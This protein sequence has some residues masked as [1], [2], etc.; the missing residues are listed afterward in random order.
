[1][2]PPLLNPLF[3]SAQSLPGVGPRI[4]ALIARAVGADGDDALVRDLLFHLPN[5][6]VD[7]RNRPPLYEMP[8]SGYV[9]VEGVVERHRAAAAGLG[10]ALAH[11]PGGGQ[12]RD[13]GRLFQSAQ[14]TG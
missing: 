12:R 13:P 14:P 8:P 5:G 10:G 2:R 1:M 4:E 9:T 6:F 7:R 11:H 3:A